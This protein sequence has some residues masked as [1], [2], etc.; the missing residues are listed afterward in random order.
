MFFFGSHGK[1]DGQF[2]SPCGVVVDQQGNYVVADSDNNR[3]QI[4]NSEGQF[5][6]KFGSFGRG[7][8]QMTHTIGVGL[9]SNGNI[10]V[11]EFGGNRLQIF[12]SQGNFIRIVG[13]GKGKKTLASLC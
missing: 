13:A 9:L 8:G 5:V 2:S 4:F 3:I 1:G 11:A 6:M 12:D 7:K 10:V